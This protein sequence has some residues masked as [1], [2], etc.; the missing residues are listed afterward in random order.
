MKQNNNNVSD[1][2]EKIAS[3][4][5]PETDIIIKSEI[6]RIKAVLRV[7]QQQQ[8]LFIVYLTYVIVLAHTS[9]NFE[10]RFLFLNSNFGY[11]SVNR[12]INIRLTSLITT[13]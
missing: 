5:G 3:V 9:T 11:Y 8:L 13:I 4:D 6:P 2:A 10:Y 1:F 12:L 7:Q